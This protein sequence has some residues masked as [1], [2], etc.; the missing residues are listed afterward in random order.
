MN[1]IISFKKKDEANNEPIIASDYFGSEHYSLL[2]LLEHIEK[3]KE[4]N[5]K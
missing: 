2:H 3:L 4:Q 5:T 1:N